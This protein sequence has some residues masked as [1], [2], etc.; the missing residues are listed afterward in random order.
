MAVKDKQRLSDVID[1]LYATVPDCFSERLKTD[2]LHMTLHDLSN[3]NELITLE[4]ELSEN[5]EGL[6][7]VFQVKSIDSVRIRMQ[8]H[9]IF[10]MV[11]T[12]LVLGLCP[13]SEEDYERLMSLYKQVNQVKQLPYL[14]TPHITLAYYATAGFSAETVEKLKNLV[15]ELNREKWTLELYYQQFSSMN[16]YENI[17]RLCDI[18]QR[19]V[20]R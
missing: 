11:N 20:E 2:T 13:E 6:Y 14:L 1:K 17:L 10:N 4:S 8:T 15:Q 12:S 16:D 3:G 7:Y 18:K 9:F 5:R 19:G